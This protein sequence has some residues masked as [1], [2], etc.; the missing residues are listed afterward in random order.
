[1]SKVRES[2]VLSI[3]TPKVTDQKLK[4]RILKQLHGDTALTYELGVETAK[5]G[6]RFTEWSYR[7]ISAQEFRRGYMSVVTTVVRDDLTVSEDR[8]TIIHRT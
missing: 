5:A 3:V 8:T 7:C 4:A 6:I 2:K 1:M